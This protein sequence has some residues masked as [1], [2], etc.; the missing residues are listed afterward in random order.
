MDGLGPETRAQGSSILPG[1]GGVTFAL[2]ISAKCHRTKTGK[3][4]MRDESFLIA[5]VNRYRCTN[6]LHWLL[7]QSKKIV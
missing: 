7:W 4:E 2:R 3:G 5:R 6:Y 1:G